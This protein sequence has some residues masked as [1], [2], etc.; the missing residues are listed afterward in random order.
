MGVGAEKAAEW[1][2][3]RLLDSTKQMASA[4]TRSLLGTSLND[5]CVSMANA[6]VLARHSQNPQSLVQVMVLCVYVAYTVSRNWTGEYTQLLKPHMLQDYEIDS[7]E[8]SKPTTGVAKDN[9]VTTSKMNATAM[10]LVGHM[11]VAMAPERTVL[12]KLRAMKG[13]ILNPP[14]DSVK[15]EQADIMR[16]ANAALTDI[17]KDAAAKIVSE[18]AKIITVVSALFGSAGAN[19]D[20]ALA[21]AAR[22]RLEEF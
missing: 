6:L 12:A 13:T 10:H 14:K 17:D 8:A 15:T 2:N 11:V 21:A 3:L 4:N 19:I 18:F 16:A 5:V 20:V 22:V 9:W 7:R 1:L